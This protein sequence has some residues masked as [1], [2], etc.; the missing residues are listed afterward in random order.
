MT[1]DADLVPFMVSSTVKL[2]EG[3]RNFCAAYES[4]GDD[5]IEQWIE[6]LFEN[7][8]KV[9]KANMKQHDDVFDVL[10]DE[11]IKIKKIAKVLRN[12]YKTANV[13]VF[14]SSKFD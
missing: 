4:E 6:F 3:T 7:A 2:P 9:S 1:V 14:N 8:E 13:I 11:V 10:D 12:E 5:F